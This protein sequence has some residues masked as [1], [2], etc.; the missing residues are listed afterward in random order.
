MN[1]STLAR[2]FRKRQSPA[3]NA[4]L[5]V[6]IF[7]GGVQKG[8]T[9]SLHGY[10]ATHP[11]IRSGNNKELHFFDDETIDWRAP[12]YARLI[13]R[14]DLG[15]A[16]PAQLID[17][18]P[19]YIFWP[20][21][22]PRIHRYN[23]QARHIY[24]FRDPIERAW[25]HWR[26]EAR[27]GAE[28]LPFAEAIREGRSRLPADAPTDDWW[29]VCSYVERGLYGAQVARLLDIVPRHA[30]LFLRSHDLQVDH[31][32]TLRRVTDFLELPPFTSPARRD[33]HQAPDDGHRLS[34][35]DA[36]YLAGLFCTDTLEFSRLT[37]LQIDDWRTVRE[38]R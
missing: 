33:D 8:G 34:P 28:T 17:A 22:V 36:A 16:V 30:V 12:D 29:R 5:R 1:F 2:R 38:F 10:L 14:F 32:A 31:E 18:T 9:T 35:A 23:P 21:A 27:R 24:I 37:G 20:P 3:S 13:D 4:A 7:L 26:M 11:A 25:S 6:N 15:T 19:I